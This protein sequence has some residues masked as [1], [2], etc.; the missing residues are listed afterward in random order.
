MSS[1]VTAGD[2]I[3]GP[4]TA[5]IV[6]RKA[7]RMLDEHALRT[8][9]LEARS[10]NGFVAQP[11]SREQLAHS[12]ELALMG[13]TSANNLPARFV[14]VTTPEAKERLRPALMPGNVEKTMAAPAT[15]IVAV[16]PN[17]HQHFDRTFPERAEMLKGVFGGMPEELRFATARDNAILQMGYFIIALRSLGLDAGPMAGFDRA[18]VDQAFFPDGPYKTQYLINIGYGDDTKLFPRL[19]RFNVDEIARFD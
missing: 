4:T 12:V 18:T 8:I 2:E 16:E 15:A 14:F 5:E 19:P 7:A 10:A 9:F 6:D 11:V 1:I 3:A 17:F 13:P